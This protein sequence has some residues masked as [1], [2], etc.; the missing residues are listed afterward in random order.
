MFFLL[1]LI[2]GFIAVFVIAGVL[3]TWTLEYSDTQKRFAAGMMPSPAPDGFYAGSIERKTSWLG[4]KFYSVNSTGINV[5]DEKGAHVEKYPFKTY[6]S[7]G[8]LK[9]DYNVPANPL[10]IRPILDEIVKTGKDAYLGKL[11]LR[12]IPGYPFTLAFFELGK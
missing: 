8:T 2:I 12:L 9:I 7:S 11:Q 10:W 3:R 5:F 4:K 1:K 6:E